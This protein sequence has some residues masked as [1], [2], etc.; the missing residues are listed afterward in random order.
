MVEKSINKRSM[1][2]FVLVSKVLP[3]VLA[4]FH[5]VNTVLNLFYIDLVIF[6]YIASISILTVA[7]L[8]FVS[9]VIRLCAYYRMFL[10]YIVIVDVIGTI[11]HYIGIPVSDITLLGI[12]ASVTLV[13]MFIIIYLKFFK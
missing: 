9:Y 5:L 6:N 3:M 8:Y 4:L 1:K 11:D 13:T 12:Y 10:H 7:Y 2:L